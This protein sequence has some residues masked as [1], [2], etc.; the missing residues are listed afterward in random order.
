MFGWPGALTLG[1]VGVAIGWAFTGRVVLGLV[2]GVTTALVWYGT[3]R[4]ADTVI[5]D[6]GRGRGG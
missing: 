4:L 2:A 5:Y 3:H 1:V 6:E